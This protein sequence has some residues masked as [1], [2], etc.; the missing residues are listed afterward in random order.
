MGPGLSV[1]VHDA[2]KEGS[3][4]AWHW[5]VDP[6]AIDVVSC[7]NLMF[8]HEPLLLELHFATAICY[9]AGRQ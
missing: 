7:V 5:I 6:A 4:T 3:K 1:L 8:C 2:S 9:A